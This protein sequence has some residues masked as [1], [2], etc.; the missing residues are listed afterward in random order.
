V[1]TPLDKQLVAAHKRIAELTKALD[2]ARTF[3]PD[4]TNTLGHTVLGT[5]VV[6]PCNARVTF[7]LDD[8]FT[9]AAWI[10]QDHLMVYAMGREPGALQ[11]TPM[12]PQICTIR[13][14]E[15]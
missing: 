2:E 5:D 12:A 14:V 7:H 9:I 4:D 3:G 10:E 13:V 15:R 1:T 8:G 6:L 11:I